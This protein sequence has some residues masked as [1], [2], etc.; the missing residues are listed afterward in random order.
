MISGK[1]QRKSEQ[2]A[3]DFKLTNPAPFI[4][5]VVGR[6]EQIASQTAE[7]EEKI[8]KVLEE[9]RDELKAGP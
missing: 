4:Q 9:I 6:M 7:S 2:D 8:L 1:Y 5:W 3:P